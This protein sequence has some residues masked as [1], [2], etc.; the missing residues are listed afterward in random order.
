MVRGSRE[1]VF[2]FFF[3]SVGGVWGTVVKGLSA[4]ELDFRS[5]SVSEV[6]SPVTILVAFSPIVVDFST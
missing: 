5:L 2:F 6:S 3:F 4:E 1:A